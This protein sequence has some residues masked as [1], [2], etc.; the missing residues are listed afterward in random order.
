MSSS[1]NSVVE[2]IANLLLAESS[3]DLT[4]GTT[5]HLYREPAMPD[6][7]VTIF[8]APGMAPVGLLGSNTD[9]KHYERPSIQIRI[10]NREPQVGFELAY[11]IL[12][13]LQATAQETWGRYLYSVISAT[14]NPTML[15]WDVNNRVRIVL[16]FNIQRR[17]S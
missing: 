16:N 2:D 9:T 7:T 10:R 14:S 15:D 11:T 5:L 8:E 17:K 3:L 1:V 6:N 12:E 13:I 4:L